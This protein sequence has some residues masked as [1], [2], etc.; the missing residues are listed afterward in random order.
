METGLENQVRKRGKRR[1]AKRQ[2]VGQ[3]LVAFLVGISVLASAGIWFM[4]T[5]AKKSN[6]PDVL[7][8]QG[9][10]PIDTLDPVEVSAYLSD[11]ELSLMGVNEMGSVMIIMYHD[12]QSKDGDWVRSRDGFREDLR[13]FYDLGYVLIPFN[14]YLTGNINIPAGKAPLVL[15]FDDGTRGQLKLIEKDGETIADPDCAVGIMLDFSKEHPDFGHAAT[16]FI[17]QYPF[18]ATSNA[19]DYLTFLL[20][21]GMEIGNHTL[22]HK[23]LSTASPAEVAKEIGALHNEVLGLCDYETKSLALPYGGYPKTKENLLSGQWEDQDYVNLGV[24]LV[25]AEPAPSPFSSK[26]NPAALP[27][28]QGSQAELDKWLANFERYPKGRF[29]SDGDAET[30][31]VRAGDEANLS[32]D[33]LGDRNVRK[34][35][36]IESP[37][38]SRG[39][40]LRLSR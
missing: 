40:S 39:Y 24:L 6:G 37:D 25:G 15:T 34:Y 31:T 33:R 38:S 3:V 17:Y 32:E 8:E 22:N 10:N 26:F 13:R 36:V 30:V 35:E 12:I 29:V 7:Q 16:F 19:K 5:H 18:G 11:D 2:P 28:I 23:N 14:D 1:G 27:R 9:S 20:D 21:N 4:Q